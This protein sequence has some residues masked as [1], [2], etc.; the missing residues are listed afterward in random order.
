MALGRDQGAGAIRSSGAQRDRR[1]VVG[2]TAGGGREGH[3]CH[4]ESE[5]GSDIHQWISLRRH[6]PEQVL[7]GSTAPPTH[8]RISVD[9]AVADLSARRK[10]R[11]PRLVVS[12][13][14][15]GRPVPHEQ[16]LGWRW[17]GYH[18]DPRSDRRTGT[19]YGSAEIDGDHMTD[20]GRRPTHVQLVGAGIDV[21]SRLAPGT[22]PPACGDRNPG[23]TF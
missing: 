6:Y 9:E 8:P 22:R 18:T 2:S 21:P 7:V 1:E 12:I 19:G 14:T 5:R 3:H 4:D 20:V 16:P 10:A 13:D 17:S 11:A 23:R 15:T